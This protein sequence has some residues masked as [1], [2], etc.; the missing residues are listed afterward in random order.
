MVLRR[1]EALRR[2]IADSH[3]SD[4]GH[5]PGMT[6][7]CLSVGCERCAAPA[8]GGHPTLRMVWRMVCRVGCPQPAGAGVSPSRGSRNRAPREIGSNHTTARCAQMVAVFSAKLRPTVPPSL[9][10]S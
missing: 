9:E 8:D 3:D 6:G 2:G 1:A 4:A 10:A 7:S 5:C